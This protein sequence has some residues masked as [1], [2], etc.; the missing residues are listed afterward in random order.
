[1]HDGLTSDSAEEA[2]VTDVLSDRDSVMGVNLVKEN[3]SVK[4]GLMNSGRECIIGPFPI[5]EPSGNGRDLRYCNGP[6][7]AQASYRATTSVEEGYFD[8]V[9]N[10]SGRSSKGVPMGRRGIS[11][12]PPLDRKGMVIVSLIVLVAMSGLFL[13]A[14]SM[15]EDPPSVVRSIEVKNHDPYPQ[16]VDI[17]IRLNGTVI[18]QTTRT[19]DGRNGTVRQVTVVA[20]PVLENTT[21]PYTVI[22]RLANDTQGVQYSTADYTLPHCAR[23]VSEIEN[24]T[25]HEPY[26]GYWQGQI[27]ESPWERLPRNYNST[28]RSI[29]APISSATMDAVPV[30]REFVG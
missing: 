26:V 7:A 30:V 8:R 21:G 27:C 29:E 25:I 13:D 5:N 11:R 20:P 1:M 18:H 28:V 15:P 17:E 3:N 16:T 6:I 23:L 19:I 22:V 12:G 2:I 9:E 14:V 24:G 4:T 10:L